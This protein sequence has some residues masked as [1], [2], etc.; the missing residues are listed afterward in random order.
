MFECICNHLKY[1]FNKGNIRSA[2][3]I[4]R[5]RTGEEH[6]FRIW[7]SQFISYA[8]YKI[9]MFNMYFDSSNQD[10]SNSTI[11]FMDILYL[12]IKF[13]FLIFSKNRKHFN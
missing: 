8:G 13:L 7:N 1:G 9:D 11:F 5:Q 3:T 4:F 12:S 10:K 2:I 6:D